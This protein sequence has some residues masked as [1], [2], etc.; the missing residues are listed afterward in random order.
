MLII[1][2]FYI[3]SRTF[4]HLVKW[5][6]NRFVSNGFRKPNGEIRQEFVQEAWK[7]DNSSIKLKVMLKLTYVH[8]HPNAFEKMRVNI[9]FQLFGDKNLKGY[10]LMQRKFQDIV[11][12][13]LQWMS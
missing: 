6:R 12:P 8:L 5:L 2:G 4:P 1:R 13:S 7:Q 10:F 11:T 3:L 9:A